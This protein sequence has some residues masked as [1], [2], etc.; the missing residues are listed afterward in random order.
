M[1]KKILEIDKNTLIT[2][3]CWNY[4]KFCVFQLVPQYIEWFVNHFKL[5]LNADGSAFFGEYGEIYS[6]SYYNAL[7]EIEEK[8][9]NALHPDNLI[10]FIIQQINRDKYIILDLN[11]QKLYDTNKEHFWLHEALIYGYDLENQEFIIPVLKHGII[12]VEK[13]V[14][15]SKIIEGYKDV[16]Q[17]YR[18]DKARLLDRRFWFYGCTIIKP[19]LYYFNSNA[20]YDFLERLQWELSESIFMKGDEEH[21][22]SQNIIPKVFTGLACIKQLANII[23]ANFQQEKVDIVKI[24]TYRKSCLKFLENSNII[25]LLTK[26]YF[27][28][29]SSDQKSDIINRQN[30]NCIILKRTVMLFHKYSITGDK[31]ILFRINDNL[32]FIYETQKVLLNELLEEAKKVYI[33]K[34]SF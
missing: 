15:F 17:Y 21:W 18:D 19:K 29:F 6:I 24:E 8:P 22:T 32:R 14:P 28:K 34:L 31:L 10:E 12:F 26:W 3:E 9:L 7:I 33:E 23:E 5:Y 20:Y 16:I 25:L 2:S 13:R 4:Y 30:E 1:V 27:K 11:Y